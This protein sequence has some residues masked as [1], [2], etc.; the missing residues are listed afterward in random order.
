MK[1]QV[2]KDDED[3][4]QKDVNILPQN[5]FNVWPHTELQ[6]R[7][8]AGIKYKISASWELGKFYFTS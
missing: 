3:K 5:M 6:L 4:V 1:G 8:N 2:V 7:N